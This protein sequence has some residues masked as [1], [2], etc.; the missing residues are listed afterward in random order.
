MT[1]IV[2]IALYQVLYTLSELQTCATVITIYLYSPDFAAD[3]HV[4]SIFDFLK[5]KSHFTR[6]FV[7]F[8]RGLW[9]W[10]IVLQLFNLAS[11][12]KIITSAALIK[13]AY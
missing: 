10:R 4:M 5:K 13:S 7:F 3:L 6:F 11:D 9:A 12:F 8:C 1:A 2:P